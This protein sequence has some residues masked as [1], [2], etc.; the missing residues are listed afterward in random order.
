MINIRGF[1][2]FC[3]QAKWDV[4]YILDQNIDSAL[5]ILSDAKPT[6]VRQALAALKEVILYKP[7]LRDAVLAMHLSQLECLLHIVVKTRAKSVEVII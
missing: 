7:D 4:D 1:R 5:S 2:L 6:A 3:K